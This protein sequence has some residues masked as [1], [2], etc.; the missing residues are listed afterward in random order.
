MYL[1]NFSPQVHTEPTE[2]SLL[3]ILNKEVLGKLCYIEAMGRRYICSAIYTLVELEKLREQM[4]STT[5]MAEAPPC[6]WIEQELLYSTAFCSTTCNICPVLYSS[7]GHLLVLQHPKVLHCLQPA[8]Q[9]EGEGDG[10]GRAGWTVIEY[11]LGEA[12][13]TDSPGNGLSLYTGPGPR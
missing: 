6:C 8:L 13:H 3:S 5:E 4:C 12:Q 1:V 10:R 7:I 11:R 9:S 2:C